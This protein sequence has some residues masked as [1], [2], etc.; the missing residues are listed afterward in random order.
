TSRL[1]RSGR[2]MVDERVLVTGKLIKRE[3]VHRQHFQHSR[4][5]LA[6]EL[7]FLLSKHTRLKRRFEALLRMQGGHWQVAFGV[8]LVRLT[9]QL[10]G[11]V[12]VLE[13]DVVLS[14]RILHVTVTGG[15]PGT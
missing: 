3:V 7:R 15:G 5:I 6:H 10:L 9:I 4:F 12:V 14:Y 13:Q 11:L 1:T 8:G 2:V